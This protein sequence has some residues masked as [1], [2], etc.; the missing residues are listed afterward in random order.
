MDPILNLSL[1]FASSARDG[2][3]SA[4]DLETLYELTVA[5][6]IRADELGNVATS[7][8]LNRFAE[9]LR[10]AARRNGFDLD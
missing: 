1:A 2:A 6:I 5:G 10:D 9:S 3:L 4:A 8:I 7:A